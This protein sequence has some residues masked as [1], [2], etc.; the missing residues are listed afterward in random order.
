MVPNKTYFEERAAWAAA[1]LTFRDQA[2]RDMARRTRGGCS[3]AGGDAVSGVVRIAPADKQPN[4]IDYGADSEEPAPTT[5]RELPCE[6][7]EGGVCRQLR[8]SPR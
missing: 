5:E 6:A 2:E 4:S 8:L 3:R 1:L 7:K